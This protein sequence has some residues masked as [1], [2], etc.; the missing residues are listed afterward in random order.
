MV[1][2]DLQAAETDQP[3]AHV[4]ERARLEL[5]PDEEQ[6]HHDA[7]FGEVLQ[8]AR[9]GAAKPSTG[10]ITMPASRYPSTEPRPDAPPAALR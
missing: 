3:V 7:E 4:P 5:Q 2:S 8:V 1:S 10:P 6:H 9:L